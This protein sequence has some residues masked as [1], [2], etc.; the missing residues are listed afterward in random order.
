MPAV[1]APSVPE[2]HIHSAGPTSGLRRLPKLAKEDRH[3]APPYW[4]YSWPGGAALARRFFERPETVFGR[5]VLDL[6]A[7]SGI[8]AIAAAKC[9]AI[10]V[11]AAEIDRN[12]VVALDLNA[13]ANGVTIKIVAEDFTR[14]EPPAV[15]LVAVGDLFYD[16]D[17]A[18]RVIAFLDRCRAAGI[19]VLIGDPGRAYLPHDRLRLLAEYPVRDVGDAKSAALGASRVFAYEPKRVSSEDGD[20]AD[21][22]NSKSSYSSPAPDRRPNRRRRRREGRRRRA[23]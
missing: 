18:E 7:G 10:E 3:T 1:S 9:R 5:R 2:I 19:D 8:V 6:G 17:V 21:P 15:D 12:A 22:S 20:G 16:N 14:G 23:R 13:R 4:A 11:I